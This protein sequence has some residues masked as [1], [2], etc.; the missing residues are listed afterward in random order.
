MIYNKFDGKAGQ[1][2]E[3]KANS[4]LV[5]WKICDR[6]MSNLHFGLPYMNIVT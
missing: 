3:N 5:Q 4:V 6:I 1:G 2:P